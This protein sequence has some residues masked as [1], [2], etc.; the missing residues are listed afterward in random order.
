MKFERLMEQITGVLALLVLVG[1]ALIVI[2][3]FVTALL[4]GGIVAYCSWG[5]Y[6]RLAA[7]FGG[8]R[9]LATLVIVLSILV[10]LIG[11]VVYAGGALAT[12]VPELVL[13]AQA[14]LSAGLPPLPDW[15]TA[16][17]LLGPRVEET[18]E[19]LIARNPDVVERMRE[20]AQPMLRRALAAAL[21]V[22][23][24]LGLLVLS[25]LFAAFF[26]LS[27][28]GIATGLQ[29]A[30]QRIAGARAPVL[31]SLIGATVKGVVFGILGTSL[32]QAVLCALGFL[33]AGLPNPALLGVLVFFLAIIPLGTLVVVVPGTI[34][35][36][37]QGE[38][39][40]AVFLVAWTVAVGIVVDNVLKPLIIGRSSHVPFILIMLGVIGGAAA[41]GLLG[42]FVG[43]TLLAVAHAVLSEWVMVERVER[44]GAVPTPAAPAG[45]E[46]AAT[47]AGTTLEAG[48]MQSAPAQAQDARPAPPLAG[49]QARRRR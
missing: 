11:P 8:R 45:V 30:M 26:Y 35:L 42:V 10:L 21:A 24:G 48:S 1:G 41:F 49:P 28:A 29:G 38:P 22:L 18:W 37:Q 39:V 12:R 17:P 46:G 25:V 14:R 9:V 6:Q 36:A 5:P 19:G 40:W 43:P 7:A 23:H 27:G 3:P 31:L 32:I 13:A 20:L 2:A 16:L 47:G 4:W 15:L 33:I 44:H 34:W